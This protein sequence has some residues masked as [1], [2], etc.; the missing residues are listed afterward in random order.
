[1]SDKINNLYEWIAVLKERWNGNEYYYDEAL[2]RNIFVFASKLE[3][4]RGTKR[5]FE[6]VWFQFEIITEILCVKRRI[7]DKRKHREAH[8]NIPRKNGKSFIIAILITFVFFC[9]KDIFGAQFILTANTTKQASQLFDTIMHF[10]KKNRTLRKYCKIRESTKTIIRK[11][12]GNMLIVLSSDGDNADSFNDYIACLDE[13]H[14]AK[15]D[16]M[17]GKLKTG[18]DTWEEPLLITI[19]T[20]SDG[21]DANNLE[22]QLYDLSKKLE[23][24]E[25]D[26]PSFYYKIYEARK[27]CNVLDEKEWF[28]ANP[29]LGIFKNVEGVR[30]M[31]N[32]CILMP[33]QEKMFRR[34][35]LNQHVA[36]DDKKGAINMDLWHK[37]V[38]KVDLEKLKSCKIW[39]GLDLSS[40]ND[41]T[42]F[43][44]IF[45]DEVDDKFIVYPFLFTP[46]DTLYEREKTDGNPYSEW[47][48]NG[49]LIALD[50]KYVNFESVLDKMF[51][52]DDEFEIVQIGFDRW[53]SQTILSRLEDK[54]DIVELGQGSRTMTQVINDFENLLI[55]ERLVIA[56]NAC[57]HFMA[58][59][60]IAVFDD[61]MNVKYSKKKSK[62]KIDGIVAMLMALLLAIEENGVSHYD[63]IGAL[64]DL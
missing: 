54:W 8:I 58:K 19:T 29:G 3:N 42:A 23:A 9:Q 22:M 48:K 36:L 51:D 50:G 15:N 20:A 33:S 63:M 57:F 32:R 17:Y 37:C 39:C 6:L 11:D 16:I 49:D 59:N 12:N 2:A 30:T 64:D 53:G 62:F 41:V 4:D 43:V 55:D 31:A 7:N 1:M 27:D 18:Q 46:K 21:E 47:I 56:D 26:D 61:A 35:H 34:M 10:I 24:G 52:I 14:Q 45:Y 38:H 40:K 13:V 25:G 28:K 60:T 44:T 5:F